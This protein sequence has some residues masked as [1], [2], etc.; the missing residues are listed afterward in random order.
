MATIPVESEK[1]LVVNPDNFAK[2]KKLGAFDVTACFSCGQCTVSCPLSVSGNEFPRKLI[3]YAVLGLDDKLLSQPEPWLCYYCGDCSESCPSQADPGEFMMAVRRHA[4]IEYSVGRVARFFYDKQ[5]ALIAYLVLTLFAIAAL[6][7]FSN[8]LDLNHVNLERFDTYSFIHEEAIH[9]VGTGLGLFVFGVAFLQAIKMIKQLASNGQTPSNLTISE[10]IVA[11]FKSF[12]KTG[13]FE[14]LFEKSNYD[15]DSKPRYIAHMAIF[16][17]FVF[18][19]VSTSI[20]FIID[21]ILFYNLLGPT[22]HTIIDREIFKFIGKILGV[23]GGI[24]LIYGTGYYIIK[25]LIKDDEYSKSSHFSD[26][27]FLL[28]SFF[29]GVTGFIINL[30]I[31]ILPE[32]LI[33][34]YILYAVHIILAFLLIIT[35]TFTKFVHMEYRLLAIWFNEYQKLINAS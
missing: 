8:G 28:L 26:W 23:L 34:A 11:I 33:L 19:G 15:C 27:I 18:M 21:V 2:I 7:F 1:A 29:L 35:A 10:K 24:F 9:I 22:T 12:I 3:R 6:W 5:L 17:G 13:I 16:W 4:I 30:F 25:R 14:G 31:F 32:M 20:I